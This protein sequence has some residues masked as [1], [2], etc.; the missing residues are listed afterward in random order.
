MIVSDS[1][2]SDPAI[3]VYVSILPQTDSHP[4]SHITLSRVPCNRCLLVI[5]LK[6]SSVYLSIQTPYLSLPTIFPHW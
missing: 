4:N 5:H 3:H 1:Q 2:Q 6:Y